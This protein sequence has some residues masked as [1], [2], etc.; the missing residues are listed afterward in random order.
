MSNKTHVNTYKSWNVEFRQCSN[1]RSRT[2]S[3][4]LRSNTNFSKIRRVFEELQSIQV[5]VEYLYIVFSER[6]LNSWF[7]FCN[8]FQNFDKLEIIL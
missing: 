4:C 2:N 5:Y 3:A 6:T 1:F 8:I 7:I